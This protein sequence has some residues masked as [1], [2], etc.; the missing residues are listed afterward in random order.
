MKQQ[1]DILKEVNRNDG[2]TVP[3]GYFEDFAA[4]MEARLPERQKAPAPSLWVR[5]K[6]YVYMAA[7]FAGIFCMMKMFSMMRDTS[8]DLNI[9]NYPAL[10]ATLENSDAPIEVLD[11]LNQYE[12][13]N[14][15]YDEG[16]TAD[17]IFVVDDS[18]GNEEEI[19]PDSDESGFN[20][21]SA[22]N[23]N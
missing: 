3:E 2:F 6:P 23:K 5:V 13:L 21:P 12:I 14:D 4:A 9:E 1:N 8:T 20:F 16:F 7:M 19:D 10:T 22:P 15:I 11:D 17:D 18:V